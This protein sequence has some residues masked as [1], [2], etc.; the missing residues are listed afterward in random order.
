MPFLFLI[1]SAT[2]PDLV[3]ILIGWSVDIKHGDIKVLDEILEERE[4]KNL[5]CSLDEVHA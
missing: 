3:S 1:Q 2:L 4:W 5:L